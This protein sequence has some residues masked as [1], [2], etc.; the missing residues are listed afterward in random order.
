MSTP[1]FEADHELGIRAA[2]EREQPIF[3]LGR[4]QY[5]LSASLFRLCCNSNQLLLAL[6]DGSGPRLVKIDLTRPEQ[7]D[8]LEIAI[9]PSLGSSSRGSQPIAT[10]LHSVF[11]DPSGR[12]ILISTKRGDVHYICLGWPK[13]ANGHRRSR[14][15]SKL[16]GVLISSVAWH[17]SS[18]TTTDASSHPRSQTA[19]DCILGTSDGRILETRLDGEVENARPFSKGAHDRHVK[20]VFTLPDR[21]PILGLAL[22]VWSGHT[23]AAATA[24]RSSRAADKQSVAIIATTASRI[25]QFVETTQDSATGDVTMLEG[26]ALRYRD[27]APRMLELPNSSSHSELH[28][29]RQARRGASPSGQ[30]VTASLAW[31]IAPGTYMGRVSLSNQEASDGIIDNAQLLPHPVRPKNSAEAPLSAALTEHHLILLYSHALKAIRI[32]DDEQVYEDTLDL[33]PGEHALG[34]VT[35]PINRTVW[36]YSDQ[37]IFELSIDN[38]SRHIWQIYMKRQNFDAALAFAQTSIQKD[39]IMTKKADWHFDQQRFVQAADY[40]AQSSSSFEY[41]ALRFIDKGERDALRNYINTCLARLG[42]AEHAQKMMLSTWLVEL[43]L[44]KIADL[45]DIALSQSHTSH[46]SNIDLERSIL[47][48]DLKSFLRSHKADLAQKVTLDLLI[49]HGRTE[50]FLHFCEVNHDFSRIARHWSALEDWPKVVSAISSQDDVALYYQYAPSLVKHAPREAVDMFLRQPA[51]EP[52]KLI[53]ALLQPLAVTS[54]SRIHV[55]RYLQY[56]LDELDM[57][58]SAIHNGMIAL[59]AGAPTE[60]EGDLL[61]FMAVSQDNPE[62]GM[63]YYD[64]DFALRL[65]KLNGH[66]Q[67]YVQIL[68]KMGLHDNAVTVALSH[69]DLDLAK[70][71]ADRPDDDSLRKKLWLKIAQ[72]VVEREKDIKAAMVLVEATDTLGIEDVL[73]FFPDFVVIDEFK[74]EICSALEVYSLEIER[75]KIEMDEAT[76]AAE[77]IRKDIEAL[78]SR[79]VTLDASDVC[80]RCSQPVI[81]RHFYVFP[82]R[83]SWHADCLVSEITRLSPPHV[84]RLLLGLQSR[85]SVAS[86]SAGQASVPEARAG[87]VA[88]RAAAAGVSGLNELRKLIIPDALVGA[89][90][91][92]NGLKLAQAV[93]EAQEA[94]S[95]GSLAKERA[96]R[97]ERIRTQIDEIL[98]SSC[99]L[100]DLS[101]LNLDKP[102]LQEGEPEM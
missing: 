56:C 55:R 28:V 101:L 65:T 34:L 72:H 48:D 66:P 61:Y 22:E 40:Y 94:P 73:P 53:P 7:E 84:L 96:A 27:S 8:Y 26:L 14:P 81:S 102:F 97:I 100:C 63:P 59:I 86:A 92:A 46:T 18:Y 87:A 23:A 3:S 89:I 62:T 30:P 25:Y 45:E 98:G 70:I 43:F 32:L 78:Q 52:T 21:S 15:L 31:L 1:G 60:A 58:D 35:D 68:S 75:L 67:A 36:L 99:V 90:V 19:C 37:S 33:R 79:F 20:T 5:A 69:G 42:K 76:S 80:Q 91:P 24:S 50:L 95:V 6:M 82:C 4:V 47:E 88:A 57:K 44:S 13:E 10:V 11:S 12:H 39:A 71:Q 83:H 54:S 77:A 51:L 38:E 16:K 17:P 85:L 64:L 29:H 41:V 93:N 74:D 9:D 49:S 2:S